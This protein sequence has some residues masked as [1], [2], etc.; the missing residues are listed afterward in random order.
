MSVPRLHHVR[1]TRTGLAEPMGRS[2]D[3]S[4]EEESVN[5]RTLDHFTV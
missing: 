4:G 1:L 5:E 2:A 3:G